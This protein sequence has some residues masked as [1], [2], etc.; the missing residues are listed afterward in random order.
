MEA[1]G[2]RHLECAHLFVKDRK[3]PPFNKGKA[4]GVESWSRR[5]CVGG[6]A[7]G[8]RSSALAYVPSPHYRFVR[9]QLSLI[10]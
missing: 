2:G 10:R 8:I 3:G 7:G 4:L 5:G 9:Q 6:W 1:E